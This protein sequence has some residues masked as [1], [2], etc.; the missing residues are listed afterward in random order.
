MVWGNASLT[1]PQIWAGSSSP[2]AALPNKKPVEI[3]LENTLRPDR[4]TELWSSFMTWQ[5]PQRYD[6]ELPPKKRWQFLRPDNH[7]H[8]PHTVDDHMDLTIL[9]SG[10]RDNRYKFEQ[11]RIEQTTYTFLR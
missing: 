1:N 10:S 3:P 4:D 8:V 6:R 7:K 9:E 11:T 2:S 5:R